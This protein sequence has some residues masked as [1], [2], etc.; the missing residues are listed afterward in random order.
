VNPERYHRER[1]GFCGKTIHP[2]D[3]HPD[4]CACGCENKDVLFKDWEKA[5]TMCPEGVMMVAR[6]RP[7]EQCCAVRV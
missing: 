6:E 4:R 2:R 5:K 3:D 1:C 7:D